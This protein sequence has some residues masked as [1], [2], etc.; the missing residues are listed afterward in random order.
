[1]SEG[2]KKIFENNINIIKPFCQQLPLTY[3]KQFLIL[4]GEGLCPS[5]INQKLNGDTENVYHFWG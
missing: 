5:S 4:R 3:S 1:M 2:L